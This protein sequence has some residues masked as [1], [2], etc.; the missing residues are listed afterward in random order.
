V[1]ALKMTSSERISAANGT[2]DC[3]ARSEFW[4]AAYTRP[5]SEKETVSELSKILSTETYAPSQTIMKQWSDRKKKVEVVV[6]PMIMFAKIATDDDL[7]KIKQ[8]SLIINLLTLPGQ[9]SVAHIPHEQINQLKYMLDNSDTSVTIE[10]NKMTLCDKVRV[11]NGCLR[12]IVG[13]MSMLKRDKCELVVDR[14]LLGY[15]RMTINSSCLE[16]IK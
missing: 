16:V 10:Q 14:G 1:E 15:A 3:E 12:G 11:V 2:D 7:S 9:K 4:V 6:I 5:R 13:E 8:H